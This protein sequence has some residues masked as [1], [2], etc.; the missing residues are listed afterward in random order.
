MDSY[1]ARSYDHL[2]LQGSLQASDRLMDR[3]HRLCRGHA[4]T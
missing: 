2:C 1:R 3:W 4:L